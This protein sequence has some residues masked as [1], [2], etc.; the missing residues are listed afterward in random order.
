MLNTENLGARGWQGGV[1]RVIGVYRR[2]SGVAKNF[3]GD[4][5]IFGMA[6]I[7]L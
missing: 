2:G 4:K 1:K 6:K 7:Y 3:M 5:G